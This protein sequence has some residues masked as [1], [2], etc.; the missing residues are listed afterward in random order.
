[1][2]TTGYRDNV[3][4]QNNSRN[5]SRNNRNNRNQNRNTLSIEAYADYDDELP[6]A[7]SD[8]HDHGHENDNDNAELPSA[9]EEYRTQ[10][11]QQHQHQTSGLFA[12]G[13]NYSNSSPSAY[14]WR[15]KRR[16]R[17]LFRLGLPCCAVILL[18][19]VGSKIAHRNNNNK[20]DYTFDNMSVRAARVASLVTAM[21]WSDPHIVGTIGTAQWQAAQWL[22]ELDPY[23]LDF[24]ALDRTVT[25]ILYP[26]LLSVPSVPSVKNG[27]GTDTG[28]GADSGTDTGTG[29]DTDTG[30]D[31][32]DSDADPAA[33]AIDV[34]KDDYEQ[35][36]Q[37]TEF[38]QR[39]VLAV[40]YYALNGANWRYE[41]NFL[42]A[43]S[44]CSWHQ[45]WNASADAIAA[46]DSTSTSSSSGTGNETETLLIAVG[47]DCLNGNQI[48]ELILPGNNLRGQIP[49]EIG[50]LTVL[51][52]VNWYGNALTGTLPDS[53]SQLSEL[54]YVSLHNNSLTGPLPSFWLFGTKSPST[55]DSDSTT[56]A[57]APELVTLNLAHNQF[58][59]TIPP[60]PP[61]PHHLA[62]AS[63]LVTL[64]LGH[65]NLHVPNIQR[66]AA[67][68]INV[69]YM[70]ALRNFFL[71]GNNVNGRLDNDDKW[72]AQHWAALEVI[73]LSDN[74]LHGKLP[75]SLFA[76]SRLTVLDLH[77]NGLTGSFPKLPT[78]SIDPAGDVD[79][80]TS[81]GSSQLRFL[82][83]HENSLTGA[84]PTHIGSFFKD[85]LIH[86][87]LSKNKFGSAIPTEIYQL[88]NLVYLF[89]AYNNFEQGPIP[90]EIGDLTNLV[91]L[92]LKETNR[93]GT[94]PDVIG[95]QLSNLALLDL[96][97][98]EM[99][100]TIPSSLGDLEHLRLLF[101]SHNMLDGKIPTTLGKLHAIQF[102][103]LHSNQLTGKAPLEIC[104]RSNSGWGSSLT[105]AN[106][107]VLD[108][109][110]ADCVHSQDNPG[111]FNNQVAD[112]EVDCPCCTVCCE[113][114]ATELQVCNTHEWYGAQDPIGDYRYARTRTRT[115]YLFNDGDLVFP[116]LP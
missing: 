78:T 97:G 76:L 79:G 17:Y 41:L 63:A 89:L 45:M 116:A 88:T 62:S 13:G 46:E 94:I 64:D 47:A 104:E 98:N 18:L 71:Q 35:A 68:A 59:G 75:E 87:D 84:I 55:S 29:T 86:L 22:G 107:A 82:A 100:G 113:D 96:D 10:H 9:W 52:E 5:S 115:A 91:D 74:D 112:V 108:V 70:P 54:R 19:A 105:N 26:P 114:S 72:V 99:F 69:E 80:D 110:M 32:A 31:P 102:L 58:T 81:S 83:L 11:Q 40:L 21:G 16:M 73:D 30:T 103:L 95:N 50:L 61:P 1:M 14:N 51:K 67:Q 60:P 12:P 8:E 39:Y 7:W 25:A 36:A 93:R 6:P 56:V 85:Q 34:S 42:S 15:Q 101:L 92:S 77:G 27:T 49:T 109:F 90:D 23:A 4:H 3:H 57:P 2:E 43:G 28:T 53:M 66:L 111:K 106:L 65:N 48:K 20:T 44:V 24:S 33:P 38:Q 37:L